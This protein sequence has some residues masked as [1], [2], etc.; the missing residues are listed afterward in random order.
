[1]HG[2]MSHRR[3]VVLGVCVLACGIFSAAVIGARLERGMPAGLD[4]AIRDEPLTQVAQIPAEAGFAHHGVYVQPTSAGFVCLWDAP[5]ATSRARQGGCNRSD[6]PFAGREL[7]ISFAYDGGPAAEDVVDARLIGIASDAVARVHVVMSDGTLRTMP[8]HPA[9][10]GGGS[11]RAFGYRFKRADLQR[12]V[13][14]TA[15]SAVDRG[16]M[17]IDRQATGFGG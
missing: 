7:F 2:R 8:L 12:G 5:A 16:G 11:Y 6:D 10:V 14:P 1:M 13:V 9:P 15:V 4:D 3:W 17:E